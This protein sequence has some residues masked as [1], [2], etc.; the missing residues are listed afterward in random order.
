M[1][2]KAFVQF[3]MKRIL[4]PMVLQHW[5]REYTDGSSQQVIFNPSNNS[6]TVTGIT[7]DAYIWIIDY[8]S[9]V[10]GSARLF[11]LTTVNAGTHT[12]IRNQGGQCDINL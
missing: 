9:T 6:H 11:G 8:A 3:Q 1:V 12:I 5:V 4:Q 7:S 10:S 2:P